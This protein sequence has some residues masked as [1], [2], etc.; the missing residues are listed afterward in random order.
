MAGGGIPDD[1][2]AYPIGRVAAL[3]GLS[4]RQI[5]Y[6]EQEGLLHTA[7]SAGRQRLYTQ[8]QVTLLH[9]VKRLRDEGYSLVEVRAML[10]ARAAAAT[11]ASGAA[12][13][14]ERGAGA[15]AARTGTGAYPGQQEISLYPMVNRT[16]LLEILDRLERR[17]QRRG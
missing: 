3:T 14:A 1:A 5:R 9:L 4:A 11:A 15:A 10:P 13:A 12:G 6:Y 2:A 7:R 16:R 8:D 17:D